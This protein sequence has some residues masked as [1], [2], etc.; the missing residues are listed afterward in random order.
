MLLKTIVNGV[1]KPTNITGGDWRRLVGPDAHGLGTRGSSSGMLH[2]DVLAPAM[3][4]RDHEHQPTL[5]IIYIIT[6]WPPPVVIWFIIPSNYN[7]YHKP[8]WLE[9]CS[10]TQ[11]SFGGHF[12]YIYIY[13]PSGYLTQPWTMAHLQMF[14][15]DLPIKNGDSPVRYVK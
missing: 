15:D 14:F 11:L 9:L 6:M 4:D 5:Y 13:I 8:Q 12:S 7:K 10:P 2:C 1:Y 3:E